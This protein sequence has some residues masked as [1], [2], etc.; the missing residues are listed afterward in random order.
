MSDEEMPL[1]SFLNGWSPVEILIGP[2]QKEARK[3]KEADNSPKP[4]RVS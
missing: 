2:I 4:G 3:K 1:N